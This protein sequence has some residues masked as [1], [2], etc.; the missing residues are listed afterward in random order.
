F[1]GAG[2]LLKGDI[3][4]E[5]LQR[6]LSR[7]EALTADWRRLTAAETEEA[8]EQIEAIYKRLTPLLVLGAG[9]ADGV[10]PCAFAAII[11]LLS[12]LQVA[13]RRPRELLAV[14]GAFMSG[15]FLAYFVL[16]LGLVEVVERFALLRRFA[17]LFNWGLAL[18]VA[19]VALL[20]V[21]DG[22][23]CLRGRMG[24]MILQLPEVFKTRIHAVVRHSARRRRFVWAAFLAG[25]AISL[26]ELACTGQVYGPTLLYVL[27]AGLSRRGVVAYLLLYNVAFV[28]PLAV[29]FAG[30]YGG[31][32]CERLTVWLRRRAALVKFA[33]AALFMVLF[34]L[35]VLRARI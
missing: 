16:G 9:L 15:V 14:G 28:V 30:A 11:F 31:L 34:A 1:C 3:T 27:K 18:V 25:V 21:W 32:R 17:R 20:N 2:A 24:D 12:Y 10:N 7:P 8:G 29:V 4:F 26:L 35:L 6:L 22:V 33:T 19:L 23:Q 5:R 13:R